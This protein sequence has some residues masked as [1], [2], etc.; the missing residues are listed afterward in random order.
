MPLGFYVL[1]LDLKM[2]TE[3]GEHQIRQ[4]KRNDHP[5]NRI[6]PVKPVNKIE[7]DLETGK[8]KVKVLEKRKN[9]DVQNDKYCQHL[10]PIAPL[11]GPEQPPSSEI[12]ANNQHPDQCEENRDKREVIH[13]TRQ[14]QPQPAEPGGA[15][16][17]CQHD[18]G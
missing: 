3:H 9:Q 14:H 17:I 12:I 13:H 2:I 11:I 18:E 7:A 1:T 16:I 5:V 6:D 10:L 8:E 15:D 4:P